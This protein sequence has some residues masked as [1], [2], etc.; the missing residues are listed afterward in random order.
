MCNPIL[1]Y[2]NIQDTLWPGEGNISELPRFRNPENG[3][4]HLMATYC[5]D[6]YDSPCID[7][8]DPD[9]F[10]YILDCDWGLGDIRSDMGAYGGGDSTLVSIENI[11]AAPPR[12]L[13]LCQNFP[14]PFNAST[15]IRYELPE[16]SPVTI[17]IFDILGRKVTTLFDGIKPAGYQQ[18]T[19]QPEGISSGI[20]FY[21]LQAGQHSEMKKMILIK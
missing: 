9:I 18:I 16:Q 6:P 13:G 2:C 1:T 3:D 11:I 12:K 15:T 8:G 14:N 10:D 4:Y 19:W 7:A 5:G 20:Y 17:E 21:M